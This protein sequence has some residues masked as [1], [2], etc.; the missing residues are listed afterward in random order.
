MTTWV[1]SFTR[2]PLAATAA[3]FQAAV[4]ERVTVKQRRGKG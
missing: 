2:H 4:D 3:K 1:L